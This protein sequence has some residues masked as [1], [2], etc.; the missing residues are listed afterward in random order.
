[1][2]LNKVD[3]INLALETAI[4]GGSISIFKDG[5]EIGFWIGQ[6]KVSQAEEI[7]EQIKLLFEN[8]KI[9]KNSIKLIA[10][11]DGPGSSTGVKIGQSVAKGLSRGFVCSWVRRSILDN[12]NC[13]NL[14]EIS[15][16]NVTAVP[17]GKNLIA[18]K[19]FDNKRVY[20]NQE[21]K[22]ETKKSDLQTFEGEISRIKIH[23]I[24]A[25]QKIYDLLKD[26]RIKIGERDIL[27][28]AGENMALF[29]NR[30]TST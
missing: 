8:L 9:N 28:N 2:A 21:S 10:V 12:L 3:N 1:M 6:T 14:S 19:I 22:F 30:Q 7:L 25:H 17:F 29:L 11:S 18:W 24:I 23:K 26:Y 15:G 27:L 16:L 13:I 20:I 5:K 4:Q